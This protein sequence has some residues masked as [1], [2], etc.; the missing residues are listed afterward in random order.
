MIGVVWSVD[1]ASALKRRPI[2]LFT[3]PNV[4]GPLFNGDMTSTAA[5]LDQVV[6]DLDQLLGADALSGLGDSERLAALNAAGEALRRVEAAIV[7]LVATPESVDVANGAGCR[8]VNELLQRALRVDSRAAAQFIK[9]SRIVRR[10]TDLTS[11]EPLPARWPALRQAMLDGAVGLT[12]L[13]AA[14]GPIDS[15]GD[16]IGAA[17]RW[18]ADAVLA[19]VARGLA[20]TGVTDADGEGRDA[21]PPATPDDLKTI[22]YAISA[23]LDPD[24]AEPAEQL[25]MRGRGLSIGRIRDGL[26]PVRGNLLPE[27]CA[28]LQLVFDAQLNPKVDGPPVPGGVVFRPS[29]DDLDGIDG[30]E[31]NSDPRNVLDTRT[32]SQKQHDAL[33]AALAIAARHK[34]MPKLGGAAPTLVV[35]LESSDSSWASIPG[36]EAPV[37]ATVARHTGCTG[38][39][40]RVF[41]EQGRIVG[42]T[43]SDRIFTPY[44]R[45]A[46][47]LRD[48]ECLIPGC[49][50][51]ASWCEIHHVIEYARGGPTS[52]DNGVPLCWWHHRS[53]EFSGW[54]IRMNEGLPE[55]RGPMWWDPLHRWRT[56]RL[57]L[58]D[59]AF[60]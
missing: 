53:L 33:A 25:A 42:M 18:E 1:C 5:V 32:Q 20:A 38:T 41:T 4:G 34:D 14:T 60:T 57:S 48:K 54:E 24:G 13:L 10:D 49:H 19:D 15:A 27:V 46:I 56:P 3:H 58:P 12:G 17:E 28:Q 51:P 55:I 11:G 40:Q 45:R 37:S 39:I 8:G 35:H 50:V 9:A 44:Q 16:R 47:V 26:H 23:Q 59:F 43:V 31:F 6:A 36:V 2:S 22:A 52:T 29:D 30:D 7:E 21:A